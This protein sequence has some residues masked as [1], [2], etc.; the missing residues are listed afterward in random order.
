M[1]RNA[2]PQRIIG[3]FAVN[4]EGSRRKMRH[5]E[6]MIMIEERNTTGNTLY[7]SFQL[8]PS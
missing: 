2:L 8:P 3:P 7:Q 1:L 5:H 4:T 6:I